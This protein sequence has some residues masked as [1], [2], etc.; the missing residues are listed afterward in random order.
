MRK[1]TWFE[2]TA[3][4]GMPLMCGRA[5]PFIVSPIAYPADYLASIAGGPDHHP[6]QKKTQ[7]HAIQIALDWKQM[8]DTDKSLT[9]AEIARS[10]GFSR[11]RVTQ[12]MNILHLPKEVINRIASITTPQELKHLSER[13]LRD[14]LSLRT[15]AEQ[16]QGFS[17]L[18]MPVHS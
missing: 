6:S 15:V 13:K 4:M 8:L 18:W 1:R 2:I 3:I 11:A 7:R 5:K 9:M 14:L 12:I 10:Q 17:K 16:L